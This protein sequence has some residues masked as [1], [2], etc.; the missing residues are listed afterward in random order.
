MSVAA[1]TEHLEGSLT[2]NSKGDP[3]MGEPA[4][5]GTNWI[6]PMSLGVKVM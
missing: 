6:S 2:L 1:S 4:K 3:G 5:V